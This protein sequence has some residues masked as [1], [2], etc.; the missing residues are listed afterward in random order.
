[1]YVNSLFATFANLHVRKRATFAD[2]QCTVGVT[3]AYVF[4]H[5]L[6][7]EAI[8]I[9][10]GSHCLHA[11]FRV[12][13]FWSFSIQFTGKKIQRVKHSSLLNV[14]PNSSVPQNRYGT[15]GI[16]TVANKELRSEIKSCNSRVH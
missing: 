3:H 15:R 8:T 13:P 12:M 9:V 10:F 11:L 6:L 16:C 5:S 14:A 4:I 2:L 1:M 7:N